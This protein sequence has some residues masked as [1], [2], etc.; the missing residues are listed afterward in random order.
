MALQGAIMIDENKS[1]SYIYL[2]EILLSP[3]NE[4]DTSA[5]GMFID[6]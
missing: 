2:S 4:I 1:R 5:N 6:H 3:L